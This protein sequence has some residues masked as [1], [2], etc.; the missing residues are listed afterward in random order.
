MSIPQ[1]IH[2]LL[3]AYFEGD[4]SP[5][6]T[7]AIEAW[8]K[9][10]PANLQLFAEYGVI[11]DM[12]FSEQHSIDSEA[13]HTVMA[14]LEPADT[15]DALDDALQIQWSHRD[16][17]RPQSKPLGVIGYVGRQMLRRYAV[18]I[19]GIAAVLVLAVILVFVLMGPG[20]DSSESVVVFDGPTVPSVERVS[21]AR[22]TGEQDAKWQGDF[23]YT[24]PKLSEPFYPGRSLTLTRGVAEI[25][26]SKGAVAILEAPVTIEFTDNDNALR[27]HNGKLIG[28][29]ESKSSQ[30][31]VVQTPHIEVT[32]LGTR[33]GVAHSETT[34]TVVHVFEGSVR[35]EPGISSEVSIPV[36]ELRAGES[37]AVNLGGELDHQGKA[38][39]VFSR[40]IQRSIGIAQLS[41]QAQ[42]A[43]ST[44]YIGQAI[45]TWPNNQQAVVMT[46][47]QR[48]TLSDPL[49]LSIASSTI[50]NRDDSVDAGTTIS[51]YILLYNPGGAKPSLAEGSIVFD[52]EILGV[53]IGDKWNQSLR[54]LKDDSDKELLSFYGGLGAIEQYD[55]DVIDLRPD[56]HTLAF[57]LKAGLAHD[58]VRIIVRE[59][60]KQTD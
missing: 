49:E 8:L 22:L 33:F 17:A 45:S 51:S 53:V 19:A 54:V 21:V 31:F 18:G 28:I 43:D 44:A 11:E 52:G 10:D 7:E 5:E 38:A 23:D 6:T 3:Q 9:E 29:C 46:E 16:G 47:T 1:P 59:P 14:E 2:D 56:G 48:F 40:L 34:G 42:W 39:T 4:T 37:Q 36:R 60:R 27:L 15:P 30:G 41:G 58:S 55:A 26:T 50:S 20:E 12:L 13:V 24:A 25:T 35:T 57:K 32:D